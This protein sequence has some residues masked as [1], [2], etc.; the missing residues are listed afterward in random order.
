MED[1]YHPTT[2]LTFDSGMGSEVSWT[3]LTHMEQ[4]TLNGGFWTSSGN[5]LV[6]GVNE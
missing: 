4:E 5:F 1:N 6:L 3:H 2:N